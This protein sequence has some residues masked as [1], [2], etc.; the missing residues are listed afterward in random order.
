MRGKKGKSK[1]YGGFLLTFEPERTATIRETLFTYKTA[2]ESFS[3]KDFPFEKCEL[4][5]LVARG[6]PSTIFALALMR[7]MRGSG[8]TSRVKMRISDPVFFESA[9]QVSEQENGEGLESHV[10]T[11]E[12]MVR[13]EPKIWDAFLQTLKDLRP[14]TSEEIDSLIQSR[15]ADIV[16]PVKTDR[17]AILLQQRD[18]LGLCLDIAELDRP[19]ILKEGNDTL[20]DVPSTKSILEIFHSLPIAERTILEGDASVF[21]DLLGAQFS[22]ANYEGLMGRRVV[23]H[24]SDMTPLETATGVDLYIY[25]EQY[26]SFLLIQYKA[27]RREDDWFYKIAG[28]NLDKQLDVIGSLREKLPLGQNPDRLIDQRL[29]DEPFYFKFCERVRSDPRDGSLCPGITI[30]APNLRHFLTL[31]ESQLGNGVKAIGYKN[32]PR[33]LN[34]TEFISLARAG[35]LGCQKPATEIIRTIVDALESGRS[36]MFAV[37]AGLPS[38]SSSLKGKKRLS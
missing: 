25:Q 12:N 5:G 11:A 37:I 33:Y 7:R 10:S 36:T 29:S 2:S 22:S 28:T 8:G 27:M 38:L 35:W 26:E 30:S 1:E 31:P 15:I 32:C 23:V 17:T 19:R 4:V 16:R 14:A 21:K 24:V 18:A 13:I 20:L 9:I 3:S 6:S 34:N